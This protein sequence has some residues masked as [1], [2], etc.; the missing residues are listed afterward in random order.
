M[1]KQMTQDATVKELIELD[2]KH[3]IH[4]ATNPKELTTDGTEIIFSKGNGI[5]TTNLIDG[6]EYIDGMSMLWNVNVGHGQQE[7]VDAA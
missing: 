7:I 2:K 5:Y 3:F 4:P 1:S 6:K